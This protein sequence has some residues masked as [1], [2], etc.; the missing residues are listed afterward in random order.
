M[1]LT[2]ITTALVLVHAAACAPPD[3]AG[4]STTAHETTPADALVDLPPDVGV[5]MPVERAGMLSI[6]AGTFLRGCDVSKDDS[7]EDD[8]EAFVLPDVPLRSLQLSEFWI[9]KYEVTVEA[10]EACGEAGVCTAPSGSEWTEVE[11]P[12]LPNLPVSGVTW[13]QANAYC[14]W[15]G[16]R[17]PTE[18][19]W[20][21]AARGDQ[22]ARR[23]PWGDEPPSCG[24]PHLNYGPD[25]PRIA[26]EL[27]VDED[28]GDVSPYGVVGMLGNVQEWV[29]DWASRS[30]YATC[31]EVD[32]PGPDAPETSSG[33]PDKVLR[34]AYFDSGAGGVTIS[35]RR[36]MEPDDSVKGRT[37]FRCARTTAPD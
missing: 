27:P 22:D 16:K 2:P 13:E 1:R 6:P 25:C 31:P 30:Y 4:T 17:L 5:E 11:P 26:H 21:K 14:E 35:K 10:Y 24:G 3:G 28:R 20:E 32:P 12:D 34:G 8:P 9:D 18:A 36:W 15:A 33:D 23:Y 37:G 29:A 19:E 7:C